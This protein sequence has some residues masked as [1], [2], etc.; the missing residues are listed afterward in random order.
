MKNRLLWVGASVLLLSTTQPAWALGDSIIPQ[1]AGLI[2]GGPVLI[3]L[4]IAVTDAATRGDKT[5]PASQ[6]Q[7]GSAAVWGMLFNDLLLCL[8]FVFDPATW[9]SSA[10]WSQY[11]LLKSYLIPNVGLAT[12]LLW[13]GWT[14]WAAVVTASCLLVGIGYLLWNMTRMTLAGY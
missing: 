2:V 10:R 5:S 14:R 13:R 6:K 3:A 1:T 12:F 4:F 7:W 8:L 11:A 9:S